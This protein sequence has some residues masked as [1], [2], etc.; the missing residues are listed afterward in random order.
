MLTSYIQGIMNM[1]IC[2]MLKE[3]GK[4]KEMSKIKGKMH[5]S[6]PT[7]ACYCSLQHSYKSS[8][9]QINGI[10]KIEIS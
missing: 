1:A 5:K 8:Y 10:D 3:K 6:M 2:I 9:Q 4:K 7:T